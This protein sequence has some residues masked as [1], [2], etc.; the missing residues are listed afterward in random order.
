[1]RDWSSDV[2]SSDLRSIRSCAGRVCPASCW[3]P[4]PV[5][6][7]RTVTIVEIRQCLYEGECC[8]GVACASVQ[9]CVWSAARAEWV[10]PTL[11]IQRGPAGIG[12]AGYYSL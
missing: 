5:D 12:D 4:D 8:C 3:P 1:K 2:C 7:L 11:S 6:P 9:Y 10:C